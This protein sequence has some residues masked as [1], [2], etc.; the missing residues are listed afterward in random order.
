MVARPARPPG[1]GFV[2][3]DIRKLHAADDAEFWSSVPMW[4]S[5]GDTAEGL[6]QTPLH[7]NHGECVSFLALLANSH[8][9]SYHEVNIFVV[10]VDGLQ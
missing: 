3:W 4:L 7:L 8:F 9:V 10:A 5:A 6:R 2:V 1:G